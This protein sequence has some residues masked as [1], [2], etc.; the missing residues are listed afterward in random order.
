MA[1]HGGATGR[2]RRSMS[3]NGSSGSVPRGSKLTALRRRRMTSRARGGV[4]VRSAAG[5]AVDERRRTAAVAAA[6]IRRGVRHRV[7]GGPVH[8]P[9][10]QHVGLPAPLRPSGDPRGALTAACR[11]RPPGRPASRRRGRP[12]LRA[13]RLRRPRRDRSRA[14]RPRRRPPSAAA[15]TRASQG[16]RPRTGAPRWRARRRAGNSDRRARRTS[17]PRASGWR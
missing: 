1:S 8:V 12:A 15:A 9:A 3:R 14:V 16:A 2:T 11:A 6:G 5:D 10:A 7:D 17:R 13:P 4:A